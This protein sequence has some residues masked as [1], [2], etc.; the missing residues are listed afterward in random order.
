MSEAKATL[1]RVYVDCTVAARASDESFALYTVPKGSRILG[2]SLE[3]L[4]SAS[5]GVDSTWSIG[6]S[7]T[8]AGLLQLTS[9]EQTAGAWVGITTATQMV[10]SGGKLYN[11]A[12]ALLAYYTQASTDGTTEP[13]I[14]ACLLVGTP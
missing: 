1:T 3:C 6:Q 8:T 13:K 12:T 9:T 4:I 14:R 10:T 11:A 5:A 2:A 7:G